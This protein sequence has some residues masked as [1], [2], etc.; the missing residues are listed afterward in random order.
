VGKHHSFNRNIDS[1][2]IIRRPCF[3]D[4]NLVAIERRMFNKDMVKQEPENS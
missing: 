4:R 2:E 3:L 1:E